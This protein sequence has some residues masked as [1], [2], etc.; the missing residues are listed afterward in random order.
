[1]QQLISLVGLGMWEALR[2]GGAEGG[3]GGGWWNRLS[4][5]DNLCPTQDEKLKAIKDL[6]MP[7]ARFMN[8]ILIGQAGSFIPAVAPLSR[9]AEAPEPHE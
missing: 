4:P 2:E 5:P 8:R 7:M 1:M 3:G 6:K 9:R